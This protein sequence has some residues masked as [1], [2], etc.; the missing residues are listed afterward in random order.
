MIYLPFA[1]K[2]RPQTLEE[3]V[4]Q[5]HVTTTLKRAIETTRVGQA[6]LFAG[7]RGVGKT[8]AARILAK[9]L[10]C[11]Q[12][13]TTTPCQQCPSCRS[14]I[15]GNSLDVI[16]IDG[17]SN[18]G[19]DEIRSLRETVQFAPT[20]GPFRM[21]IIDEVHM[22][23]TEAFNALLKTLEE[24]PAHVKFIFATTAPQKVLPT[25]LSRCQRFDF[26]RLESKTIVL[27][28]QRICHTERLTIEE[29]ALYAIAR[30]ADGSL[31]DAEVVLEQLV[32]FCEGTIREPD[33]TQLLGAVEPDAL[34]A[35]SQA[36]LD[37]DAKTALMFLTQQLEQGKEI[38]QLF[39]GLLMHWRNLLILRTTEGSSARQALLEQLLDVPPEQLARLDEQA[40][41]SSPEELLLM[42]QMLTGA[43]E[44]ARRSPFAQAI[45]EFALIKLARRESWTSLEQIIQRLERL[46][47]GAT[48][49]APAIPDLPAS[50]ASFVPRSQQT[51][52][53][54]SSSTPTAEPARSQGEHPDSTPRAQATELID[55]QKPET[56]EGEGNLSLAQVV[57]QWPQVLERIAQQKMSLAA[58]L[59]SARPMSIH[60]HRLD[61]GLPA[62]SLHQEVL[63]TVEHLRLVE[64][65]LRHVFHQP[66][67]IQYS[68]LP[69]P[70]VSELASSATPH[71]P[72]TIV[73]ESSSQ[74][75]PPIVQDIVKLFDA[76][77]VDRPPS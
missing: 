63:T 34:V 40:Q 70:A 43:Y 65:I 19:I 33:V 23:T 36:I 22:L 42:L 37:R 15:Q 48:S 8:S 59:M 32:S 49:H 57:E 46:A 11:A 60:G 4:G 13:P 58:Y 51:P 5:P 73:T 52:S 54:V 72:S 7:Q 21:Y 29:P 25:I 77:I 2:Y 10:N 14:I 31:R 55:S 28:L 24:P 76:T 64:Q 30:A 38:T 66:L 16:E 20:Q 6:Y 61:V 67:G 27:A 50:S 69:E 35:W 71:D 3:L 56:S 68:T 53:I 9:C 18:R 44:L 41:L 26:R 45:L 12:G 74:P 1:R 39:I 17:A 75:V 62:F 47:H